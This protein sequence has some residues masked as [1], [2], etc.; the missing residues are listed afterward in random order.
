MAGLYIHIP[1]CVRK[2][3]YCDFPSVAG[4]EEDAGR[5]FAAVVREA[6]LWWDDC[7][8]GGI[9]RVPSPA[10]TS[11]AC[12]IDSLPSL[13]KG[14]CRLSGRG[15]F[16]GMSPTVTGGV[17]KRVFSTVFLGGGTPSLLPAGDLERL[18]DSLRLVLDI[19]PI[20]FTVEVNPG[21]VDKAKLES[22]R[23]M[24]A[25]RIS[26]GVQAAQDGLLKRIGRIHTWADF[27]RS[28]ELA[29]E[30]GFTNINAD[31]MTGLP[32][33]T[34]TDA[35]DTARRLV[36]LGVEHVSC[37][38]LILEEGTP[39][40]AAVESGALT[41]PDGDLEREMFHEAKQVLE[42]VGI[43]RYEISNF[44]KPGMECLHNLTYWRN[45]DW[46]GLGP[47][48]A[49]HFDGVRWENYPDLDSYMLAL[50]QGALPPADTHEI[51]GKET[52]FES[53]MLGLRLVEG[54]DLKRFAARHGFSFLERFGAVMDKQ[55]ELGLMQKTPRAVS[56]TER[57]MD[58]QN[59]V[60]MEFM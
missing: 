6:E 55:V 38:G 39:M 8:G 29:R 56:L 7:V 25:N 19:C 33:Q 52:A 48:A 50:E 34:V 32:G 51:G 41:V 21:T 53:V 14:G 3:A 9:G 24:G 43:K 13:N 28:F 46:L 2:C 47:G 42:A 5:F 26:F 1:F 11:T 15:D 4:R 16:T 45:E 44:A 23:R 54:I 20:E 12:S 27:V 58:L 35:V 49:S 37:Y 10:R 57:G 60:L 40:F 36:A 18:M 31:M 59:S 17:H 30:A 22:F